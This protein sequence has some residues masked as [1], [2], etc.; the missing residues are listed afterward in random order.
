MA[1]KILEHNWW[2]ST[3]FRNS[4]G[5]AVNA[6]ARRTPGGLF[7][8][9]PNEIAFFLPISDAVTG[10]TTAEHDL[11]REIRVESSIVDLTHNS[12]KLR[13]ADAGREF[14]V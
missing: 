11:F 6:L 7:E 12:R 8:E 10:P 3:I 1:F 13:N 5:R 4:H 14:V 9:V 2:H